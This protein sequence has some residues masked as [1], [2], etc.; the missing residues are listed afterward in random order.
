MFNIDSSGRT[1]GRFGGLEYVPPTILVRGA[2][3][4]NYSLSAVQDNTAAYND[5]V[6]LVYG[7][8]WTLPDV[9]FL[10]NDGN[11]TRMEVLL[12]MG[13]IEGIL[14][15]LVNDIEIPQGIS[16]VNMTST[17]WYNIIT[18]GTRNGKQDPNFADASGNPLGDPYGSMAYLSVVVPNR[19]SDGTSIPSRSGSDAGP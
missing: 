10:R 15:V 19:I 9:V 8:Q 16:G 14:S 11:L 7:T 18:A 6:P 13:E 12:G 5:F 4:K 1:T 3:Q 17:G 2:G